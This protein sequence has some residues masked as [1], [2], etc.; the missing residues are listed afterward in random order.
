MEQQGAN[1]IAS[2]LPL[3][4]IF[5]VFYFLLIRPQQ[6]QKKE[7]EEMVKNLA[8]NDEVITSGGIH[9]TIVN[10]KDTSVVLRIDDNSK[11]EVEKYAIAYTTKKRTGEEK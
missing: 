7:H 10:V 2:F 8:K 11:M 1:A 9:G 6:K 3:I 4:L 5:V